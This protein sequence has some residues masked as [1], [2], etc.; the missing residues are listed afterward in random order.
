MNILP[1]V[2][3]LVLVGVSADIV[4]VIIDEL[5]I[6][7]CDVDKVI[8]DVSVSILVTISLARELEDVIV[9]RVLVAV[10]DDSSVSL[11]VSVNR[12]KNEMITSTFI[13]ITNLVLLI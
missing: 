11:A 4:S 8:V 1:V 3:E 10:V 2:A 5:A 13:L 9:D 12:E 6:E 7:V